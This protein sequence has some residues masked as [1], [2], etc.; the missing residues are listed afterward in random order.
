MLDNKTCLCQTNEHDL[1][2][3]TVDEYIR[4]DCLIPIQNRFT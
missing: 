3:L 4:I 1:N 2:R